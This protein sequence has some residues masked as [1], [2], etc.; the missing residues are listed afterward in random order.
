MTAR[1]MLAGMSIAAATFLLAGCLGDDEPGA[2]AESPGAEIIE[3]GDAAE[4]EPAGGTQSSTIDS[5]SP[6][7][8]PAATEPA[9]P[10]AVLDEFED[11]NFM[12]YTGMSSGYKGT[13]FANADDSV[14]CNIYES[15]VQQFALC[16]SS[17]GDYSEVEL[18]DQ[19][20]EP[21]PN[22]I[23][24]GALAMDMYSPFDAVPNAAL[25]QGDA[26]SGSFA[27]LEPGTKLTTWPSF[28]DVQIT[29]G[30]DAE[31]IVCVNP[32]TGHGFRV[33]DTGKA[34]TW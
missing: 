14:K 34:Q 13:R 20:I 16:L 30:N 33:S 18:S 6:T 10:G 29:C 12:M 17:R 11:V 32:A 28:P 3:A 4:S 9:S 24:W 2:A 8:E 21:V 1:K 23:G 5:P 22:S 26:F 19:A 15:P 7:P 25:F 31:T 27:I